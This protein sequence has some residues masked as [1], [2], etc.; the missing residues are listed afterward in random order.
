MVEKGW[1]NTVCFSIP[2]FKNASSH[3]NVSV[4][5][6]CDFVTEL[7]KLQLCFMIRPDG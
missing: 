5:S 4:L 2:D 3:G 7:N 6:H 1:K